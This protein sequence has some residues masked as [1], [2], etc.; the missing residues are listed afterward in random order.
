MEPDFGTA[1]YN[2]QGQFAFNRSYVTK[3]VADFVGGIPTYVPGALIFFY[4]LADPVTEIVLFRDYFHPW[5]SNSY[6]LD[7][8]VASISYSFASDPLTIFPAHISVTYQVQGNP[9]A[10][11]II[12]TPHTYGGLYIPFALPAGPDDYWVKV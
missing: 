5:S 9:P 3:V 6:T 7:G 2:P 10:P 12:I 8:I 1:A 11:S 4:P